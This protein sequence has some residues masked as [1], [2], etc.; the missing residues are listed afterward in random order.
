MDETLRFVAPIEVGV[1][2]DQVAD[3]LQGALTIGGNL[4]TLQSI[5]ACL[6]LGEAQLWVILRGG[7]P[8][9]A[10]VTEIQATP[11]RKVCNVWLA[12]G[13]DLSAGL[14]VLPQIESWAKSQ[15]ATR[16]QASCRPGMG[17]ALKGEGYASR[18]EVVAKELS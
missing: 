18:Y 10:V 7:V 5:Q 17:K 8:F 14:K 13:S 6:F 11:D 4:W 3:W 12:G 1:Y 15:G 2:W 16:M 9:M